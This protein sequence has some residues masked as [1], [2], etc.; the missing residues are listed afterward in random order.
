MILKGGWRCVSVVDGA[1]LEAMAGHR[2]TLM[3]S[4]MSLDMTQQVS[5]A[6]HS[7]SEETTS[8]G[9][10]E[11]AQQANVTIFYVMGMYIAV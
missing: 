3:L 4:A 5:L 10:I 8:L 11:H 7:A 2:P 9:G 6:V 1:P